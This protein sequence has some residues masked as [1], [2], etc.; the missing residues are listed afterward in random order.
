M[1]TPISGHDKPAFAPNLIALLADMGVGAT[2]DTRISDILACMLDHQAE[3]GRFLALGR[4]SGQDAAV[5]AALPCDSHAIAETLARAGFGEDP[6]VQRSM[7]RIADDLTE[8]AQGRAWR[9]RPDPAIGWRGPGRVGD[10]CLQATLEALRAF[11]YLPADRRSIELLAAGRVVLSAWRN[12]G[13]HKPQMFGHGRQFK[14]TKWPPTWYSAFEVID[15]L[16]RYPELWDGAEAATE[17]R[18]SMAELAACVIAYNFDSD[19]RVV[20]MSCFRG[21]EGYSFGQKKLPSAFAT[22]RTLVALQRV[23]PLAEDIVAIDVLALPSSMGGAGTA[24]PP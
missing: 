15:V 4:R 3:D 11:S 6:R 21:F 18:Q 14:R 24:L 23:A 10:V 20:P 5:W 19:G 16:G 9:C 2:D 13:A 17:D 22:A 7:E 12:R 8:T 1:E